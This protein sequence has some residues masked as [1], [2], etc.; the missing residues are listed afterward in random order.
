MLTLSLIRNT[1][2][3]IVLDSDIIQNRRGHLLLPLD[4]AYEVIEED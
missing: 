2:F 4:K 1:R 3:F